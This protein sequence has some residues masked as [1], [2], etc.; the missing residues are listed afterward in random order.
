MLPGVTMIEIQLARADNLSAIHSL[1]RDCALPIDDITSA[2]LKHFL[3]LS[4]GVQLAGCIGIEPLGV[5]ALLRSLAVRDIFRGD[6]W[7]ERLVQEAETHARNVGVSSLFLL[8]TT[9]ASFFK[10]LGYQPVDRAQTP[11]SL[12]ETKQFSMLRPASSTC[13]FKSI[14]LTK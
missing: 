4:D 10:R 7:G 5:N 14:S 9:A 6:G 3:I 12:R 8:T 13:L 2:H 11:A 1:L